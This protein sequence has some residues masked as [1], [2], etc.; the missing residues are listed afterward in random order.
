[1]LQLLAWEN[2]IVKMQVQDYHG[3]Y[4]PIWKLLIL[5]T[6][7]IYNICVVKENK[8]ALNY[9]MKLLCLFWSPH[10]CCTLPSACMWNNL[11]F[12][13][14]YKHEKISCECLIFMYKCS[15]NLENILPQFWVTKVPLIHVELWAAN[16][17]QTILLT[18][19]TEAN[20]SRLSKACI[21]CVA[22]ADANNCHVLKTD[23]MHSLLMTNAQCDLISE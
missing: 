13:N 15:N 19:F 16:V 22:G 17:L 2:L 10:C 1:M 20:S 7:H 14:S 12:V 5:Q 3:F 23:T 4:H 6:C 11:T 9:L 8:D 18:L 21:H